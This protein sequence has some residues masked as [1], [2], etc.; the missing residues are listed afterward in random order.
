MHRRRLDRGDLPCL[1]VHFGED[2]RIEAISL[3]HDFPTRNGLVMRPRLREEDWSCARSLR[4]STGAARRA[5]AF[6]QIP[7]LSQERHEA[8]VTEHVSAPAATNIRPSRS[9]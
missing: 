2:Y 8:A 3:G 6:D 9:Q 7:A 1:N 5:D 4:P